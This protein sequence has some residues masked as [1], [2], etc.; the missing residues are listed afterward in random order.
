MRIDGAWRSYKVHKETFGGK[1]Y[2]HY[3]DSCDVFIG[4]HTWKLTN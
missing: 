4:V 3:L 2:V 1:R